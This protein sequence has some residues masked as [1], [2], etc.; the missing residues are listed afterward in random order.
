MPKTSVDTTKQAISTNPW[1]NFIPLQDC[2]LE[3]S[4]LNELNKR[5]HPRYFYSINVSEVKKYY[6]H[7]DPMANVFVDCLSNPNE[8]KIKQ[9]SDF[10]KHNFYQAN[11]DNYDKMS[12]LNKFYDQQKIYF[13]DETRTVL[14]TVDEKIIALITL[15]KITSHPYLNESVW[16]VGY[17]GMSKEITDISLRSVIKTSWNDLLIELN[18]KYKLVVGVDYF[19]RSSYELAE[20]FG[21]KKFGI[22]LDPR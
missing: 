3:M 4:E 9:I 11:K 7:T 10:I 18:L 20:K 13:S 16:H 19:N 21:Y 1:D 6:N 12:D 17:W 5:H 15:C 8:E 22:R 2:S 14:H